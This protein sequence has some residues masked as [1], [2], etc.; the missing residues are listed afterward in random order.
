MSS[1][2]SNTAH[3]SDKNGKKITGAII[4]NLFITVVQ[5][6]GGIVSGS[7]ALISDALHNFTDATALLLSAFA[8][9]ISLKPNTQRYTFGYKRAEILAATFNAVVLVAI[10]IFLVNE[11]IVRLTTPE[12]PSGILMIAV[13]IFGLFANLGGVWLLHGSIRNNLN[14]R[15]A[16]LHLLSDTISSV[17]IVIGGIF[18]YYWKVSW[19]DP[20][21]TIGIAAYVSWESYDILRTTLRIIMMAA[22]DNLSLEHIGKEISSIDGVRNVHHVHLW[23]MSETDIHFEAHVCVTDMYVSQ[24]QPILETIENLL[25]TKYNIHHVTIQFEFDKCTTVDLLHKPEYSNDRF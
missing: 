9:R 5:I 21:L 2:H 25:A 13:G 15:S 23:Q 20:V 7:L 16:Y 3:L 11:A 22:P 12:V 19:I 14:F 24:T 4:L 10:S 1:S 6:I 17:V 18:I 8:H